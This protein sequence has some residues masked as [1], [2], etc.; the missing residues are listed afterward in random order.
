ME[1]HGTTAA[2]PRRRG[3]TVVCFI[4]S[5]II[6]LAYGLPVWISL[7]AALGLGL[8]FRRGGPFAALTTTL[9]LVLVTALYAVV[10]QV[11]GLEDA[12]YFQPHAKFGHWDHRNHHKVY[13]RNVSAKMEVPHGNLQAMTAERIA[14]PRTVRFVTDSQGFRNDRDYHGQKYVLVGDSFIVAN[15]SDQADTL[16]A[17]LERDYA[18]STYNLSYSGDPYDYLLYVEGF[19]RRH[20]DDFR[21]LLFLFEGNDFRDSL[22]HPDRRRVSGL[23]SKLKRLRMIFSDRSVYRVTRVL[24]D[25]AVRRKAI[26][27]SEL[28]SVTELAAAPFGVHKSYSWVSTRE[29]Y[30]APEELRIILDL[31]GDNLEHV[32][33][34]PTKYRV[35]HRHL[36]R[37][38]PLP[39]AQWSALHEICEDSDLRCTDLTSELTERSEDLLARGELTWWRDD[40]H[41]N[42]H[43]IAVAAGR[44]AEIL[45]PLVAA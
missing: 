37:Q 39:H 32:F 29:Q 27:D 44:V 25:R 5:L 8:A 28:V 14:Q 10:I 1:Q 45:A 3:V 22:S 30:R 9:A 42:R 21:I 17:Q 2:W 38:E 15:G 43:G 6:V 34:I 20:G 31:M 33:F 40:T 18:I 7:L 16:S 23:E 13:R 11:A 26:A 35:Y 41:W 24:Y 36:G 4:V 19:R 12:I